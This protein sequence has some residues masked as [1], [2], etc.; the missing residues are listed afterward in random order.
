MWVVLVVEVLFSGRDG[1]RTVQMV[2]FSLVLF[3]HKTDVIIGGG[4]VG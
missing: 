1:L 3:S 4:D 2:K